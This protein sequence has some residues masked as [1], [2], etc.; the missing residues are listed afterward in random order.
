MALHISFLRQM[1]GVNFLVVYA[2]QIMQPINASLAPFTP[3]AIN[4]IQLLCGFAA[5][6]YITKHFG[7]RTMLLF[8]AFTITIWNF[9]LAATFYETVDILIIVFLMLTMISF[10]STFSPVSWPYPTE[11]ITPDLVPYSTFLN[12]L[13]CMIITVF[14]PIIIEKMPGNNAY[15]IFLFF[16]S[17]S[18][19]S[20]IYL[21]FG[22]KE[23]KGLT[24][25]QIIRIF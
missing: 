23:I 10:G 6:L 8:G 16:G 12:W 24:Y 25:E 3:I 22:A 4:F 14:P 7:R 15:P 13:G 9:A 19:L 11:I 20:S 18:F 21:Y 17:Y 1:I 2:G 5:T